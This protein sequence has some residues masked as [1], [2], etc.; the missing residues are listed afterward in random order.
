MKSKRGDKVG[1]VTLADRSARIEVSLFAEAYQNAQALL[2]KDA[3]LVVEGEVA[4]DDFSGG[5]RMR[6]KRVM[7][8]EE[9][10]TSLLDSVRVCLD[11]TRHSEQA[12]AKM[13]SLFQQYRGGCAVTVELQRPDSSA[14]LKLGEQWRVEPADDLVQGLRDQLGKDSVSLHYR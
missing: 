9:A 12:L 10:R 7:S 5:L 3:L 14:V 4:L 13:A 6:A 11:T 8:L 1:F 2:Q